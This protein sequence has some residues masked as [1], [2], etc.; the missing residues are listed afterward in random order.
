MLHGAPWHYFNVIM[1][2]YM[3]RDYDTIHDMGSRFSDPL[4]KR[5]DL[6]GQ[7]LVVD[8]YLL[9]YLLTYLLLTY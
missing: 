8:A 6:K 9:T 4:W 3:I 1:I 2:P 7:G 5:K